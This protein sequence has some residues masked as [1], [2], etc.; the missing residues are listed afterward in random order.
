MSR[1]RRTALPQTLGARSAGGASAT[2]ACVLPAGRD[3]VAAA[4]IRC[5]AERSSRR[6][7]CWLSPLRCLGEC[8]CAAFCFR[9]FSAGTVFRAPRARCCWRFR[10]GCRRVLSAGLLAVGMV[11]PVPVAAT[12]RRRWLL[13]GAGARSSAAVCRSRTPGRQIC[14]ADG[15]DRFL[16]GLEA[17]RSPAAR[18]GR[19]AATAAQRAPGLG[20]RG[21]SERVGGLRRRE[22]RLPRAGGRLVAAAED[23]H[24]PQLPVAA[25]ATAWRVEQPRRLE[26]RPV[27][28]PA[29]AWAEEHAALSGVQSS[30]A[31]LV[32]P[33]AAGRLACLAGGV[34]RA[35][36]APAGVVDALADANDGVAVAAVALAH[37]CVAAVD[38]GQPPQVLDDERL[39]GAQVLGAPARSA[40]RPVRA[41][42]RRSGT[43]RC[44][45]AVPAAAATA[46]RCS[47]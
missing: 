8:R 31:Q 19:R 37:P 11:S 6:V 9:I 28:A 17:T 25:L 14:D 42:S 22:L 3:P 33:R 45:R 36:D 15:R 26:V 20:A 23:L 40:R 41:R 35:V 4:V 13:P 32:A 12:S 34:G 18:G 16:G 7:C 39:R 21:S 1:R 29:A 2:R 27:R 46:W 24:S 44:D 5:G 30:S 38:L 43:G 10:A 47:A